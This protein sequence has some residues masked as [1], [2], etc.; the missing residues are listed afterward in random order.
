MMGLGDGL[1]TAVGGRLDRIHG[2]LE[3]IEQRQ[4]EHWRELE[5]VRGV[6]LIRFEE[7]PKANQALLVSA[8]EQGYA[9]DLKLLSIEMSAPTSQAGVYIGDQQTLGT[10][11]GTVPARRLIGLWTVSNWSQALFTWSSHQAI[12]MPGDTLTVDC[13]AAGVL[14]N[15]V[16]GIAVE[17]P[18]EMLGKLLL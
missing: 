11:P 6:K 5:L 12:L 3:E 17:V 18:A 1:E 7:F 9:W 16:Y 15:E 10:T 8:P 4:I 2:K 14:A 13:V